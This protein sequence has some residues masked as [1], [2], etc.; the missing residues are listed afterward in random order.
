M[1][2]HASEIFS[3]YIT[4]IRHGATEAIDIIQF[5]CELVTSLRSLKLRAFRCACGYV[6]VFA[7]GMPV[8]LAVL[9]MRVFLP[10]A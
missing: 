9:A 4:H 8:A 7:G 1:G 5:F 3:T 2:A 6:G 10:A